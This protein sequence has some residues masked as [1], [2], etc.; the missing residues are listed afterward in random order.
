[1]LI[2]IANGVVK[3]K[4][5]NVNVEKASENGDTAEVTVVSG[6]MI[7]EYGGQSQEVDQAVVGLGGV[8]N[9]T[10]KLQKIDGVWLLIR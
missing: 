8:N 5:E 3:M 2:L 6:K 7:M 1:M 10:F 9:D 4:I